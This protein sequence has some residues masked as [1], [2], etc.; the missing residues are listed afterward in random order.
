MRAFSATAMV[1]EGIPEDLDPPKC[2]PG[3][4]HT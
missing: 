1:G 3:V 2:L 4:I